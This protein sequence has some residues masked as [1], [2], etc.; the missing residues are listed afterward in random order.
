MQGLNSSGAVAAEGV[1]G[2]GSSDD[3]ARV[4]NASRD[5]KFLAGFQGDAV[6]I[7]DQRVAALHDHHVFVVIVGVNGGIS[8]LTAGPK[9]H[10]TAVHAIEHVAFDAWRG[11][12]SGSNSVRGIS[13]ELGKFVHNF[14]SQK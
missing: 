10:L 14:N 5:E 13:H 8:C 6:S 1:N 11:L 7:D 9:S 12:A 2:S 3:L 4:L